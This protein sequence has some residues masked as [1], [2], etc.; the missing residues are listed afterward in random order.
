MEC[1]LHVGMHKTGTTSIQR[2]LHKYDDGEAFYANL[3]S[4]NQSVPIQT[5]FLQNHLKAHWVNEGLNDAQHAE[6]VTEINNLF[7]A[8]IQ[9]KDRKKVIF[10][11]ENM[12]ILDAGS[13]TR[14]KTKVEKH[15]DK[16]RVVLFARNPYDEA[17]SSFQEV[18]K[19]GWNSIPQVLDFNGSFES[20]YKTLVEVFGKERVTVRFYEDKKDFNDDIVKYFF[21]LEGLKTR[22]KIL[23][24]P[25]E[26]PSVSQEALKLIFRLNASNGVT[27]QGQILRAARWK[28]IFALDEI[29]KKK[30]KID[31]SVFVQRID[32]SNVDF[33]KS[34]FGREYSVGEANPVSL[35]E[36]ITQ[37]DQ[38]ALD[39]VTGFL[40]SKGFYGNFNDPSVIINNLYY[41]FFTEVYNKEKGNAAATPPV[42]A[43]EAAGDS[44][45]L[46]ELEKKL[47]SGEKLEFEDAKHLMSL[48]QRARSSDSLWGRM[49]HSTRLFCASVFSRGQEPNSK[50]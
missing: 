11:G 40:Q 26:N 41:Y 16:I 1:V 24:K 36:W 10:S 8:A 37:F 4:I 35:D 6:Q 32:Q 17:A 48:A 27:T 39:D 30:S 44:M 5:L 34:E 47:E 3:K 13:L 19:H 21:D 45:R 18:V 46:L 25:R 15:C 7:S 38:A 43:P 31:K 23:S 33:L 22:P 14:L 20:R 29:I 12:S 2:A 9:R 49:S 42:T 28:T 50:G